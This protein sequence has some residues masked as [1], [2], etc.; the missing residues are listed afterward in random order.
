M[1]AASVWLACAHRSAEESRPFDAA[2]DQRANAQAPEAAAVKAEVCPAVV[3]EHIQSADLS[4]S[5]HS[6]LFSWIAEHS[7]LKCQ[8]RSVGTVADLLG[9]SSDMQV[10]DDFCGA[11]ATYARFL[12]PDERQKVKAAYTRFPYQASVALN[13]FSGLRHNRID[14]RAQ[15]SGK[16]KV[17]WSFEN[18]RRNAATWHYYLYLAS[19][20]TPGAY[21]AIEAK[22][23]ATVNGNN[24]TNLLKSLADLGSPRVVAILSLYRED[25]RTADGPDGPGIKVSETVKTLLNTR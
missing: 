1:V 3:T 4:S 15:L 16:I 10:I 8:V 17:D 7:P 6:T 9:V 24:L 12:E 20:D 14:I 18:P 19:L 11:A 5:E 25:T 2:R 21:E 13:Y 22:L 23:A